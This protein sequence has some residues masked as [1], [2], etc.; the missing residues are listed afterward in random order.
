MSQEIGSIIKHHRKRLGL[1]LLE[2]QKR[3][4]INNGNLSKIERGQ[5]SLTNDSMKAI[6]SALGMSLG[7]L[8]SAQHAQPSNLRHNGAAAKAQQPVR[9]ASE[10]A[11]FDQ[12]SEGENVAIGTVSAV[13][14]AARGGVKVEV[15]EKNAHLFTGGEVRDIES[16]P[17]NVGAY[18]IEDDLMEPRLYKGDTVLVDLADTQIPPAGG[19]FCVVM[20]DE[21]AVRRLMPYPG[22][23]LRIICDNPKY[24]E[25]VLDQ[26]QALAVHI[27][28][29]LKMVR[30]K[31]GL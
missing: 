20:D 31:Q 2:L 6:A 4:G 25:A 19:V 9:F 26:R 22:R 21:I 16:V 13:V 12:I 1:T 5:Q 11:T 23:G 14:D 17:S 24:P 28:G 27:V 15:D 29:R 30:S 7:D 3:T 10:Y 8:F 18:L